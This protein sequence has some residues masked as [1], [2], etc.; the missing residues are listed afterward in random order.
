MQCASGG[1]PQWRDAD[2]W[3][4]HCSAFCLLFFF[5][6]SMLRLCELS[7]FRASVLV[8]TVCALSDQ[9]E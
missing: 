3:A 9:V 4:S 5:G 6:A 8:R 1:L 2:A 7:E